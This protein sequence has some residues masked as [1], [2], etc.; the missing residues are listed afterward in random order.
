MAR[1][2]HL[3]ILA[4]DQGQLADFYKRTFGMEEVHRHAVEGG[5]EAI[6]LTD[7]EINLAILPTRGRPEG[8]HHFGMQVDSLKDTAATAESLGAAKGPEAVPR[9][10]RFAEVFIVDPAGTRVDLSEAG[11]KV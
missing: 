6:Y 1:I 9:D 8:L 11:W 3:A 7:G 5:F 4:K 2:R 10:G